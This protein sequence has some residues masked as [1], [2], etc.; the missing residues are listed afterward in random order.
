MKQDTK[1]FLEKNPNSKVLI[2][3]IISQESLDKY[4]SIGTDC[5]D[6]YKNGDSVTYFNSLGVEHILKETKRFISNNNLIT[7]P[8]ECRPM[9]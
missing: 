7:I 4:K 5:T 6:L 3:E 8:S 1:V 9:V 2:L